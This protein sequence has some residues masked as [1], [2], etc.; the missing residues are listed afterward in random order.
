MLILTRKR[1]QAF[2]IGDDIRVTVFDIGNDSV[3]VAIDAPREVKILREEL[4]EAAEL[5]EEA[6][7]QKA[8]DI[9]DIKKA[10]IK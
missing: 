1:G 3:R 8:A 9:A 5:N 10:F 6:A 7:S 2:H 4:V